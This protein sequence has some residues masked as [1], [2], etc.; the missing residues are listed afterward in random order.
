MLT[1]EV[2]RRRRHFD[3]M[4]GFIVDWALVPGWSALIVDS[5]CS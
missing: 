4:D 2:A 3:M 1:A 5:D